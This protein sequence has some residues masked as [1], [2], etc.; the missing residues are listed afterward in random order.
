MC[1]N[2]QW[3]L[4]TLSLFQL[5]LQFRMMRLNCMLAIYITSSV[6]FL[7][8]LGFHHH[9]HHMHTPSQSASPRAQPVMVWCGVRPRGCLPRSRSLW[10]LCI[11]QTRHYCSSPVCSSC[12]AWN[13]MRIYFDHFLWIW[14]GE[15]SERMLFLWCVF[16]MRRQQ[17]TTA[18]YF[19]CLIRDGIK[20]RLLFLWL[21]WFAW[22]WGESDAIV[23]QSKLHKHLTAAVVGDWR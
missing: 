20:L 10:L 21:I 19:S 14:L 7:E 4:F 3:R 16:Q 13:E 9:H 11:V 15:T 22:L 23:L 18:G 5:I 6:T 17:D 1:S 8:P 2:I 12:I